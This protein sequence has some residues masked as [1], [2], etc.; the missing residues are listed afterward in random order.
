M[1]LN[2][3][4]PKNRSY[5]KSKTSN[6]DNLL[7]K[8]NYKKIISSI[9]STDNLITKLRDSNETYDQDFSNKEN[10]LNQNKMINDIGPKSN[11]ANFE[12]FNKFK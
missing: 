7:I 4:F 1:K 10:T 12:F 11:T 2:M 3:D 5:I 9:D 6:A 8:N